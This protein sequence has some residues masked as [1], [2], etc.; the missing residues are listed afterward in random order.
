MCVS[1]RERNASSSVPSSSVAT[2]PAR[3]RRRSSRAA[4]EAQWSGSPSWRTLKRANRSTA[5]SAEGEAEGGGSILRLLP[6]G[7]VGPFFR[8]IERGR[9]VRYRVVAM[10]N[11]APNF[12]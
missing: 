3:R 5:V 8:R 10:C 11:D 2:S 9:I 1:L 6:Y 4:C 7:V 12:G